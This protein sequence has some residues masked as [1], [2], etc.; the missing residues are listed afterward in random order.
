MTQPLLDYFEQL[1]RY[2]T[3]QDERIA[4][5]ERQLAQLR[6]E[7]GELREQRP[8]HI[9][10][11][12]YK[13]DQLKI[14]KLEGALHIGISPDGAQSIDQFVTDGMMQ[15]QTEL[16]NIGE[17]PDSS[18]QEDDGDLRADAAVRVEKFM[19]D[20]CPNYIRDEAAKAGAPV[21]DDYVALMVKDIR[22]Q[23]DARLRHYVRTGVTP[24]Q[25]TGMAEHL[26]SLVIADVRRAVQ[27]HL[28]A[29]AAPSPEGGE[30][31]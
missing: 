21:D 3:W 29:K 11:I 4:E 27:R 22:N 7:V 1:T 16:M 23:V 6:R 9:E 14:E 20:E 10:R 25:G 13:F 8:V 5:L 17:L 28:S 2:L 30:Q 26:A 18:D 15:E 19:A 31:A 24:Q 12:D